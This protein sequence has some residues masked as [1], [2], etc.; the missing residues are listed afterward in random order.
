MAAMTDAPLTA[1]SNTVEEEKRVLDAE[2]SFAGAERLTFFSDAVVAI[3]ITLLALELPVP[4][5]TTNA[6]VWHSLWEHHWEY[7]AF[8][9][10]FWVIGSH[11]FGHHRVFRYV[12]RLGGKLTTYNMLWLMM[13]V[14]TPWATKSLTDP[15]DHGTSGAVRF[16]LYAAVQTVAGVLFLLMAREMW[17][18]NLLRPN[19][20]ESA[21][22]SAYWQGITIVMMFAVS[23]PVFWV[24]DNAWLIWFVLPFVG[25]YA[26][27]RWT[28]YRTRVRPLS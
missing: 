5:G 10:S 11:W 9:I 4:S 1:T 28:R 22:S 7:F 27:R 12:A 18:K 3:A 6:A 20:P 13:M 23:V 8:L 2:V 24:F 25:R 15:G 26:H 19:A 21:R 14:L 16:T 17:H